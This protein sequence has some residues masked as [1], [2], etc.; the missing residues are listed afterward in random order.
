MTLLNFLSRFVGALIIVTLTLLAVGCYGA[1]ETNN[2][3]YVVVIGL[4]KAGGGKEKITYQI[5]VPRGIKSGGTSGDSS[6]MGEQG[7]SQKKPRLIHT[8]TAPTYAQARMLLNST[9]S[10]APNFT[11]ITTFIISEEVAHEELGPIMFYLVRNHDFRESMF[12]IIVQGT[13]EEYIKQNKPTLEDE[14]YK[15]YEMSLSSAKESSYFLRVHLNEFYN[16]LKNPGGSAYAVYSGINP[17]TGENKSAGNKTPEQKGDPYLPGGLPRTGTENPAEFFGLAVFRRDKMVGVL[18]SD[19][20]RAVALLQGKFVHSYVG[21]VD[22][23][24]P[25]KDAVNLNIYCDTKPTITADL[26]DNIA[27]FNVEVQLE[28]E[29]FGITSGINYEAPDYRELLEAQIANLF[30]GQ[31]V[32]ML[33]HTQELG[34]DPVGFGLY[35]RPK[36][37]NTDELEQANLTALYPGRRHPGQRYR[38]NTPPRPSMADYTTKK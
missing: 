5:A 13:A 7:G 1:K 20:T 16:R 11:H 36:F 4:D 3:A 15:Y 19:E 17:K 32:S 24:Q 23:L 34:T 38:Q 27:V 35:L 8:I 6:S 29:I 37:N 31:I 26:N 21:V 25:K 30:K 9:M 28:C 18:N 2:V 12:L 22:P 10:R 14:I 33:K